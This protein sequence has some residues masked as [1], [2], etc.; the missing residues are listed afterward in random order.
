MDASDKLHAVSHLLKCM[1]IWEFLGF[2]LE[3]DRTIKVEYTYI[4]EILNI[5][6]INIYI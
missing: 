3:L 4:V 5:Q 6:Y 1:G 2:D